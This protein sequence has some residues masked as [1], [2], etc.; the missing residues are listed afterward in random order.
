MDQLFGIWKGESGAEFG[1]VPEMV[2]GGLAEMVNVGFK[3][4]WG[5]IFTP[6][7]VTVDERGMFVPEKLMLIMGD[8]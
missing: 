7:F 4:S 8:D 5:S 2:E 3:V 1:N 6:R